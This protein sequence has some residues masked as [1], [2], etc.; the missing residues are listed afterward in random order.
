MVWGISPHDSVED[1]LAFRDWLGMSFPILMDEGGVVM[2]RY[3][4]AAAFDSAVFPQDWIVG[5][6]GRVAYANNAY[7]AEAI[8]AVLE[9][10]LS[11]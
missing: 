10:E 9:A 8:F 4:Q 7:D 3:S 11:E 1:L 6:D 2:G 5:S